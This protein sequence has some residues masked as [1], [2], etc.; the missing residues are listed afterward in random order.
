MPQEAG[1][2]PFVEAHLAQH[3]GP[4]PRRVL[5]GLRCRLHWRLVDAKL[6]EHRPKLLQFLLV[7]AGAHLAAVRELAVAHHREDQRADVLD[8]AALAARVAD[9]HAGQRLP[10][11]DLAP[12]RRALAGPVAT[13]QV[14]GH[15]P[16]V[17]LGHHLRE[18]GAA[19]PDH[20]VADLSQERIQRRPVLG[21]LINEYERAA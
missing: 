20:P 10:G 15:D 2:C 8:A 16:L 12:G 11:L 3:L 17:A 6:I 9:D 5:R 7:E 1:A 4:H 21:G 14:L 19:R 18:E 13:R